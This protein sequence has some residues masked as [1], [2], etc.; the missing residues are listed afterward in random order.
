MTNIFF[1]GRSSVNLESISKQHWSLFLFPPKRKTC[2]E[3]IFESFASSDRGAR[4]EY[5]VKSEIYWKTCR[6]HRPYKHVDAGWLERPGNGLPAGRHR[7]FLPGRERKP[8]V[9]GSLSL[10][11][12]RR[13]FAELT[14]HA[15]GNRF[16]LPATST[17]TQS[18]RAVSSRSGTINRVPSAFQFGAGGPVEKAR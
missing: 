8:R 3:Q 9:R 1:A 2:R 15:A 16:P 12:D 13:Q 10:R 17:N 4:R 7:K 6:R 14:P 18:G 5:M 11:L